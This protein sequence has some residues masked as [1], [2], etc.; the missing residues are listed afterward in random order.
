MKVPRITRKTEHPGFLHANDMISF[1]AHI[2][3]ANLTLKHTQIL[4][5][6]DYINTKIELTYNS[7][8]KN[9]TDKTTI[10]LAN[11]TEHSFIIEEIIYWLRITADELI[12]LMYVCKYFDTQKAHP[13]KIKFEKIDD[14]LKNRDSELSTILTNHLNN[15]DTLNSISNAYKHSFVNSQ[16]NI[17]GEHEPIVPALSLLHNNTNNPTKFYCIELAKVIN[18]FDAFFIFTDN[19]LRTEFSSNNHNNDV[20]TRDNK[21]EETYTNP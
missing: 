21:Y 11:I 13:K 18:D 20:E 7:Y 8:K 14:L 17:I 3:Y 1:F 5:R 9:I 12:S 16:L 4:Q 2:P 6:I 10:G 19:Y 15:L